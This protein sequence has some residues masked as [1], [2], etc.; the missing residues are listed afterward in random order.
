MSVK[1]I[2]LN[3]FLLLIIVPAS[4]AVYDISMEV[5]SLRQEN[6]KI[7]KDKI[8][9]KKRLDILS[10]ISENVCRF[11]EHQGTPMFVDCGESFEPRYATCVCTTMCLAD[12]SLVYNNL[13]LEDE[14]CPQW[15][16]LKFKVGP[17]FEEEKNGEKN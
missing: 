4:Y 10:K 6:Q 7:K 11:G 3:I 12:Y 13:A 8:N 5:V 15:R 16:A 14:N 2:T 1:K 17:Q 9:L